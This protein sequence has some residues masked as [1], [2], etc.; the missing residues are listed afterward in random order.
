LI[1]FYAALI[2][3]LVS[4]LS[5]MKTSTLL[6]FSQRFGIY[7]DNSPPLKNMAFVFPLVFFIVLDLGLAWGIFSLMI[8]IFLEDLSI[9][10]FIIGNCFL[11][12]L[13]TGLYQCKQVKKSTKVNI[14]SP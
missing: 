7:R 13:L 6:F 4:F 14:I 12:G 5:V 1:G 11:S 8:W 3:L 10:F 2:S 9:A